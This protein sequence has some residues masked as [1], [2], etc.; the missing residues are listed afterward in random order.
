MDEKVEVIVVGTGPAGLGVAAKLKKPAIIFESEHHIGGLM[1]S[2]TVNQYIFDW[3]AIF[4]SLK[5]S[6]YNH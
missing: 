5:S 2:K 1:R 6:V 4:F 3:P